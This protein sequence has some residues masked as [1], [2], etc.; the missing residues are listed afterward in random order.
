MESDV[1]D[2]EG[3]MIVK[4]VPFKV[5]TLAIIAGDGMYYLVKSELQLASGC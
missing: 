3:Q 5:K 2:A 4:F 1:R